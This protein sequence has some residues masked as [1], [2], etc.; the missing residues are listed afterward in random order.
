MKR[1]EIPASVLVQ[2]IIEGIDDEEDFGDEDLKYMSELDPE[3]TWE[4]IAGD[5]NPWIWGGS[6]FNPAKNEIIHFDGIEYDKDIEPED[7][8]IPATML[9]K[10]PPEQPDWQDNI[11]RDR[12]IDH[13]RIARAEFLNNRKPRKFWRIP[14]HGDQLPPHWQRYEAQSPTGIE[15]EQWQQM[16]LPT[17]LIE[18]GGY[19]GMS[20][21]GDEFEMS[22]KE[23]QTRLGKHNI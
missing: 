12:L 14:V 5:A 16:N 4:Q 6:W 3:G 23:A 10:L 17:K 18:L 21:I 1:F 9:A 13:Y 8:E 11:D 20:E 19:F 2:R 15:D 7:V 22:Y